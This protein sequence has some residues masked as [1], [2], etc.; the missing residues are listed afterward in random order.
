VATRYRH[1]VGAAMTLAVMGY[2]FQVMT[3]KLAEAVKTPM[4]TGGMEEELAE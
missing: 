3:D 1:C 2:H 4:L